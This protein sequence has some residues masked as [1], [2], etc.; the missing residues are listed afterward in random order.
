MCCSNGCLCSALV[1]T[2]VSSTNL[3]HEDGGCEQELKAFTSNSSMNRFA[4]RGL[5]GEPMAAPAPVHNT[6]LG[7]GNNYWW[8]RTPVT[9]LFV[10]LTCWSFV[11][12]LDPVLVFVWLF[13]WMG[14]LVLRWRMPLHHRR[15]LPPLVP[16]FCF[17]VVGWN[18]M[19][20]WGGGETDLLGVWWFKPVL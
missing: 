11:V 5:M 1:M 10:V 13:G 9:V 2:K 6:Y 15:L 3:S 18:V 4:M 8:V 16:A 17:V 19:C 14:L 12:V 20:F 7:W